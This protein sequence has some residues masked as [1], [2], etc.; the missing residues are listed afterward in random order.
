MKRLKFLRLDMDTLRLKIS[1]ESCKK[2]FVLIQNCFTKRLYATLSLRLIR[3]RICHN[4]V[5]NLWSWTFQ[6]NF[7][8]WKTQAF[9][10]N[11]NIAAKYFNFLLLQE[12]KPL[13]HWKILLT[14]STSKKNCIR[15]FKWNNL[16][17]DW[18]ALLWKRNKVWICYSIN[19]M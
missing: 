17:N 4:T 11:N 3:G 10:K 15:T 13:L 7:Y 18:G 6:V 5:S 8:S 2:T 9:R 19:V 1:Q 12:K 16:E 14:L